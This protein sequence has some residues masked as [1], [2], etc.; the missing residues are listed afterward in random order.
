LISP[1]RFAYEGMSFI[2]F[3]KNA[4]AESDRRRAASATGSES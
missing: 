2:A 3:I 1:S 4:R